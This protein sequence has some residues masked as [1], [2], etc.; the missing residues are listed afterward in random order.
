MS[1]YA[2]ARIRRS[3]HRRLRT[4]ARRERRSLIDLIDLAV[5]Q[6]A[7]RHH[8]AWNGDK[9]RGQRARSRNL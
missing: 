2:S 9:E 5:E 3:T 4:L 8:C 6:Y 7:H 1:D